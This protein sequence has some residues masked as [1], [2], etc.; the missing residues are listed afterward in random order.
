MVIALWLAIRGF[1]FYKFPPNIRVREERLAW[2]KAQ[3][4]W[5]V[6][7][8]FNRRSRYR[9]NS[10]FGVNFCDDAVKEEL[11]EFGTNLNVLHLCVPLV[12]A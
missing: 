5:A 1:V 8:N 12:R 9:P 10:I 11:A 3:Y 4:S 6:A 7:G 2:A